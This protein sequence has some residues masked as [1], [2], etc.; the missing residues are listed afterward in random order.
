MANPSASR[1]PLIGQLVGGRYEIVRPIGKGGTG[2]IYEVRNVRLGH[3]FALKTL[4]GDAATNAET[5]QRFRREA[6]I[7]ARIKHP[8]IVEVID[9]D[10][11]ADGSPCI[12]MEYLRGEDLA[13]RIEQRG[14]LPWPQIAVIADQVLAALT[15]THSSGVVHRDLKPHN[16]FIAAES[17]GEERVKLLDFGVSKIRDSTSLQTMNDRLVGTPA[18]MAPEQAEG[19]SD[20]VGSHTDIW[21]MA[22]IL[23]EM[24]TG[25]RA[26]EGPGLPA[27][28]YAVCHGE[29]AP[30]AKHRPDA[31]A[32]FV[33][34]IADSLK[35]AIG[36]RLADA[37]VMR[38]RLRDAL[39]GFGGIDY[40]KLP[41]LPVP[42]PV[43]IPRA[44]SNEALAD[45]L[46]NTA[47]PAA[48]ASIAPAAEPPRRPR[49]A[50]LALVGLVG[51]GA[52]AT[53]VVVARR[54][55][56][57]TTSPPTPIVAVVMHDAAPVA[58]SVEV[59]AAMIAVTPP[60]AGVSETVQPRPV[61][62]AKP[63]SF[64]E[65]V[66]AAINRKMVAL[67]SCIE[68]HPD[69]SASEVT[70]TIE[71]APDGRATSVSLAPAGVASS[72]VGACLRDGLL[73]VSYP[74][75]DKGG[76]VAFPL[77]TRSR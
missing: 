1:D 4:T 55:D 19:R 56:P 39:N 42:T 35:Q 8:N 31:P 17:S 2:S 47:V 40:S 60:D 72:P 61:R 45:T 15:T 26:F 44:R 33:Q 64:V 66:S 67:G 3:S 13:T 69:D 77:R 37:A 52:A 62:P 14:P 27:I 59:D 22:I 54:K 71:I 30:I 63:A 51:A 34:L 38:T 12:V 43:P 49:V 46:G 74:T 29:P 10:E 70:A 68:K 76:K 75:S 73:S 21:A 23:H 6:D 50:M 18:Y 16:I 20:D 7:V 53:A 11:L 57:T 48:A 65:Q 25:V 24:A 41:A 58:L 32:A 9:W 36:E 28:L 5:I